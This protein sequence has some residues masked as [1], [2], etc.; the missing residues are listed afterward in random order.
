MLAD[1]SLDVPGILRLHQAHH[2]SVI[3][4]GKVKTGMRA[5]DDHTVVIHVISEALHEVADE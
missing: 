1:Q 4:H 2:L 5:K 3:F